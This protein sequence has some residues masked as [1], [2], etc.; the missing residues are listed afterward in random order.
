MFN[1]QRLKLA[2]RRRKLSGKELAE[3]INV[4]QVTISR[5][6]KGINNPESETLQA[7]SKEL[8]FPKEFFFG[9]DIDELSKEAASFRSLTSMTAKER[10]AALSAGSIAY[11]ISDW[12]FEKFNL[13]TADLLDLGFENGFAGASNAART[14]RQHWGLG[15]KPIGN[16]IKLLESKGVRVFSLYENTK[17]IDAFSCWRNDTPYI[18]LNTFKSTERSRFDAAHE[19][20]HLVLHK[21]GGPNHAHK[22][23][24]M[25]ANS[26]ASSFLMPQ[27][28]VISNISNVT[29]IKQLVKAKKRWKVSVAALAYR[30]HKLSIL[31]DWQYR[32]FCIQ[33]RTQFGTDEPSPIEREESYVFRKVLNELWKEQITKKDIAQD[34]SIELGELEGLLFGLLGPTTKSEKLDNRPELRLV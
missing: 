25:E 10:E 16:M 18:F 1:P 19:L 7:I 22:K 17:S 26:F 28:D 31:S 2:R 30:L 32:S 34:L 8:D 13:P 6:E 5:L 9:S 29:S 23:A 20:G 14:L 11:L 12:I 24:E 15:E 3:R 21:H 27:L 33:I 4:S